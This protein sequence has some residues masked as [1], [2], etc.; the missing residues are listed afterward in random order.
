MTTFAG[1]SIQAT[2]P[3]ATNGDGGAATSALLGN[4]F[5]LFKDGSSLYLADA[6]NNKV[7]QVVSTGGGSYTIFLV[8]GTGTTSTPTTFG[9]AATSSYLV[10]PHGL[11]KDAAGNLY[12]SVP[13]LIQTIAT[14]G[15]VY[16]VGG[17]TGGA[18]TS[19]LA[20][21][22][23]IGDGGPATSAIFGGLEQL[24]GDT[25]GYLYIADRVIGNVRRITLSS[26]L[27]TTLAGNSGPVDTRTGSTFATS[28]GF[29]YVTGLYGDSTGTLYL[30]CFNDH[31]VRSVTVDGLTRIIAGSGTTS[32][33]S[34]SPNGDGDAVTSATFN[35][36]MYS[37]VDTL[38]QLYVSDFSNYKVRMLLTAVPTTIP[39]IAPSAAPSYYTNTL[40]QI[41]TVVG[42][43]T[44]G[45]AG[46]NGPAITAQIANPV[47]VWV[48]TVGVMYLGLSANFNIRKVDNSGIITIVSNGVTSPRQVFGD[49]SG[50]LFVANGDT[51]LVVFLGNSAP[52]ITTVV[53]TGTAGAAGDNGPAIAAQISSPV[54]VWAS[55]VGVMYLGVG[56]NHNVRKV[57]SG[58]ISI[59][60]AGVYAGS[61][62]ADS[63]EGDGGAATSATLFYPAG[64]WRDSAAH[65]TVF[66]A[67]TTTH[68]FHAFH[69]AQLSTDHSPISTA[70]RGAN[71]ATIGCTISVSDAVSNGP[72]QL[73]E[74]TNGNLYVANG[75]AGTILILAGPL[76]AVPLLGGI[77]G[78][79]LTSTGDGGAATSATFAGPVGVYGTTDGAIYISEVSS[80][81]IRWISS[82]NIVRTSA[83]GGLLTS[84]NIPAT[85]AVLAE[86]LQIYIDTAGMLFCGSYSD[87]R[88]RTVNLVNGIL[89]SFAGTGT[90]G[91]P[92][93]GV[94]TS[95]TLSNPGGVFGDRNGVIYI[96]DF[97]SFVICKVSGGILSVVA[98]T[99]GSSASFATLS[100]GDGGAPTSAQ[101]MFPYEL[102]V[103][104]LGTMYVSDFSSNKI[105]KIY[106]YQPT[107]QPSAVPSLSVSP[108]LS[109]T[110]LSSFAPSIPPSVLPFAQP[111]VVPSKSPTISPS[112]LP[113]VAPS[114]QPSVSLRPTATPTVMPS[115]YQNT[116]TQATTFLGTG[117]ASTS[118]DGGAS[119]YVAINH[120]AG[121]WMDTAGN[122]FVAENAGNVIRSIAAAGTVSTLNIGGDGVVTSPYQ[123][124]GDTNGVLYIAKGA[125][126]NSVVVN[127]L[128]YTHVAGIGIYASSVRLL[129]GTLPT[130]LPTLAP[131]YYQN[132]LTSVSTVLG[133]GEYGY[134][135]DGGSATS[136]LLQ[137]PYGVGTKGNTMFV[138]ESGGGRVRKVLLSLGTV[139]TLVLTSSGPDLNHPRQLAFSASL[140]FTADYGNHRITQVV[141]AGAATSLSLV[142]PRGVYGDMNG[143]LYIADGGSCTI[144]KVTSGIMSTISGTGVQVSALA[145]SGDGGPP[146]AAQFVNPVEVFA[147]TLGNIYV[148]DYGANKVRL[149]F[150]YVP[151]TA[152]TLV[153]S[154]Q[155]R[156]VVAGMGVGGIAGDGGQATSAGLGNPSGVWTST[157]GTMASD[158]GP[159]T[160]TYLLSPLQIYGDSSG[161][162]YIAGNY[163]FSVHG[164]DIASGIINLIAGSGMPGL[165]LAN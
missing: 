100:N 56:T 130:A 31:R 125:G 78:Q 105:R 82:S 49:S 77:A 38:G 108:S 117:V 46:D 47:G 114:V 33:S 126:V 30:S 67:H 28:T 8:G 132:T 124:C 139:D 164:V 2:D 48:S 146:T 141:L 62:Q 95:V 94:A 6:S 91:S 135:G 50:N 136:A 39:S 43:G 11:W 19:A 154:V 85:S 158:G 7:R 74:D 142:S 127:S 40:T 26:G 61:I 35:V 116:L 145:L 131:S 148:S 36:P 65:S 137:G 34:T 60:A 159:A 23:A 134:S 157:D 58:T 41:I 14:D 29:N 104:T 27:I 80:S 98:G 128:T 21:S 42:T 99:T 20:V 51:G 101:F 10:N 66:S 72:Y 4:V 54:G 143:N 25:N 118:G 83:G 16:L 52:P 53:G 87:S 122:A 76:S 55:S 103:T 81:R 147:D 113:S 59:L 149:L 121:V 71:S 163:D 45:A 5:G 96:T 37:S 152:P 12:V 110:I 3:L 151:T 153:P 69:P 24:Y 165:S 13:L 89:T 144:K 115:K 133:T 150:G 9:S 64:I 22:G 17:G 156:T 160:S 97:S 68:H 18:A 70:L 84:N 86:P 57:E 88:I 32:A 119:R 90:K 44:A 79:V 15:N 111:T 161:I 1:S 73:F 92:T 102:Y 129:Y 138:T 107:V 120:P 106:G 75:G 63:S 93:T 140:V 123:I 112:I 155:P 162:L 109:P